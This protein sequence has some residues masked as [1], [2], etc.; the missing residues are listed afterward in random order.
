MR[1]KYFKIIIL[2]FIMSFIIFWAIGYISSYIGWYGYEK[3]KDRK[4]SV[5]VEESI[6]RNV[7]VKRMMYKIENYSGDHFEFEPFIERG[8]KW[9]HNTSKETILL[10]TSE[11]PYQ[12]S[13]NYRPTKE[14]TLLI[15]EGQSYKFD[16]ANRY[17]KKP[18]LSDTILLMIGGKNN[19]SGVIKVW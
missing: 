5:S 14:I 7:F 18:I 12:L 6:S 8:F 19:T 3:W 1:N 4:H 9:G 11:F 17:L 16:S 15:L 2:V 10:T 13:Y